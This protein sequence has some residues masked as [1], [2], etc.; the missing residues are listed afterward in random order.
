[1]KILPFSWVALT[2]LG[3]VGTQPPSQS[4][5]PKPPVPSPAVSSL[6]SAVPRRPL[7]VA[8]YPYVPDACR[9]FADAKSAFERLHPDVEVIS[10]SLENYYD[11]S[12][13]DSVKNTKANVIE[14]DSVFLTDLVQDNR[15][16]PL[17]V[18]AS[19]DPADFTSAAVQAARQ[20]DRWVG[21]P[22][23][24]CSDFIFSTRSKP[25]TGTSLQHLE[26]FVGTPHADGA[27]LL[28]D[29]M[30]KSTIGELYLDALVDETGSFTSALRLL[31]SG[32]DPTLPN[33]AKNDL[34]R[35]LGLCDAAF[36]RDADH[37]AQTGSYA[38]E[39]ALKRGSAFIGYSEEIH[40][41]LRTLA[42]PACSV[43]G[44]IRAEDIVVGALP[45]A[46]AG[47]RP[48]VWVDT[49]AI[50][51][52]CKEACVA[53]AAAFIAMMNDDAHLRAD[54]FP[55]LDSPRYLLPAKT[56]LDT[57]LR[58][59]APLYGNFRAITRDAPPAMG[60]GLGDRLRKIG[61]ELNK[62]PALGH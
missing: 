28:V 42:S 25:F 8:L 1:M 7:T 24:L 14:V 54:L 57:E 16:V 31:A 51:D 13:P 23:W 58:A 32:A 53:D 5:V 50:N 15:L 45:L 43:G 21:A 27:G 10:I 4:Q 46:D 59:R 48:F 30:G 38:R 60:I 26:G 19:P 9:M 40:F 17:P 35:L 41:V 55:T 2:T 12:A 3:C 44:C 56:T 29:M 6:P 20:G 36:C 39:F 11:S 34:H 33:A 18:E 47:S 52:S 49:L 62:D 22:H 61:G 37:H